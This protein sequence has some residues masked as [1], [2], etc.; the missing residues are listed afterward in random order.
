MSMKKIIANIFTSAVYSSF[1]GGIVVFLGM[2]TLF[3]GNDWSVIGDAIAAAALFYFITAIVSCVISVLVVGPIY[4]LLNSIGLTNY[5]IAFSLG[6]AVTFICFGLSTCLEN[7]YWYLAG[8]LT[9]LLFHYHYI[10]KPS[11]VGEHHLT[12]PSN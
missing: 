8:G 12:R 5:Y 6:L 1:L 9:G 2:V 4:V 10:N 3:V 11:W 7:V